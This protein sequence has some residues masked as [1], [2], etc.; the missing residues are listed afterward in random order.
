MPFSDITALD[1]ELITAA[2]EGRVVLFLGAGASMGAKNSLGAGI[3]DGKM[4]G[5]LISDKYLKP[6]HNSLDF[7]TICDFACS[8]SSIREVQKYIHDTLLDF[9]PTK[10]HFEVPKF[11]WAGLAT[12]NY[13]ILIERAYA[14]ISQPL[15]TLLTYTRNGSG[16][17]GR[18]TDSGVLFV[19]LHGCITEA[20]DVTVPLVTTR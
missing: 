10:A 16:A 12:T 2:Q 11:V 1:P 19:K 6:E 5:Q 4:L 18:L 3:P 17:V 8:V 9:Q 7:K 20:E 14:A 15:Q 13:D